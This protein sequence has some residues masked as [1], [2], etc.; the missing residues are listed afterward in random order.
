M[1]TTCGGL[2]IIAGLLFAPVSVQANIYSCTDKAGKSVIKSEP[3]DGGEAQS[4]GVVTT[5]PRYAP[6][7][8][9]TAETPQQ[10]HA[11]HCAELYAKMNDPGRYGSKAADRSA[12]TFA[13]LGCQ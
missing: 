10:L 8:P 12:Q 3:C 7:K 2:A 4:G 13:A 5:V 1:K 11:R 9:Q 6:Q